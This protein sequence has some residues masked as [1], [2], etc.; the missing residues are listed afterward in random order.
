M[1]DVQVGI[2]YGMCK[3]ATLDPWEVFPVPGSRQRNPGDSL[4]GNCDCGGGFEA[5]NH[6][7]FYPRFVSWPKWLSVFANELI[8]EVGRVGVIGGGWMGS[9]IAAQYAF[10][11]VPV[12][13]VENCRDKHPAVGN[14]LSVLLPYLARECSRGNFLL[15]GQDPPLQVTA[16]LECLADFDLVVETITESLPRK[17]SILK[18]LEAIVSH[19]CTFITGTS[20]IPVRQLAEGLTRP[21]RLVA[22]HFFT[23]FFRLLGVDFRRSSGMILPNPRLEGWLCSMQLVLVG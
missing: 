10:L 22:V 14:R 21:S 2:F 16:D 1:R 3:L 13:L 5:G 6:E 23:P 19:R 17:R 20:A 8:R 15:A 18:A 7:R 9:V 11:G 12:T 4:G